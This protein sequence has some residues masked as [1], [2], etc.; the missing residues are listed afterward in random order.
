YRCCRAKRP[1]SDRVAPHTVRTVLCATVDEVV[2]R[3]VERVL[4]NP[5]LIA[6]E[7][8]RQ[9]ADTSVQEATLE[10]ERQ[11][12]TRQLA[13]CA[14]ELAKW[15][16]AYLGDAIDLADFKAKKADIDARRT[17]VEQALV[18]LAEQ[19]QH[20]AQ[21]ALHTAALIDYCARI[22]AALHTFTLEEKHLAL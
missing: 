13:Q 20:L 3:A 18:R 10:R 7:V 5:T 15:E 1:Y 6:E 19:Q 11:S 12:Y 4:R 22:A 2:W 21:A 9:H 17:S 8:E 16:R 14:K